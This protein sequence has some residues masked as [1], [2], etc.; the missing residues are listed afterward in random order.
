[1]TNRILEVDVTP[2]LVPF[3]ARIPEIIEIEAPP[4]IK[5]GAYDIL[6]TLDHP[7]VGFDADDL[8]YEGDITGVDFDADPPAIYR[9]RALD[10]QPEVPPD[11][12]DPADPPDCYADW[13]RTRPGVNPIA[14][15][16]FLLRFNMPP[17]ASGQFSVMPKPDAFRSATP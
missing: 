5:A 12:V 2:I 13:I 15:R 4:V 10:V 7:D 3:N 11:P 9:A 16:F 1:M 6:W 14:T 17:A 8:I